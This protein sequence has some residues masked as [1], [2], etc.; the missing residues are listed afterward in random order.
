MSERNHSHSATT[1]RTDDP[2]PNRRILH[3]LAGTAC[4]GLIAIVTFQ[5]LRAESATSQT[6]S[7]TQPTTTGKASAASNEKYLGRVNNQP[8]SYDEV[9]RECV[10][11]YGTDVLEKIINRMIIQQECEKRGI[12][13][14]EAE[15]LQEVQKICKG[16]KLPLDTY[17][18]LLQSEQ[19]IT[20]QQYHRHIIWPKLALQK[21][22]GTEVAVTEDDMRK[23]FERDY[24]PRVEVRIIM[25]DGNIRQANEIWELC[26]ANPQDFDKLAK[27]HSADPNSR[28]LGGVVPPIRKHA[29]MSQIEEE[30]FKLKPGEISSVIQVGT[31]RHVIMKCEGYTKPVVADVKDV[32]AELHEALMEEKTQLAVAEVFETLKE[33][34]EVINYLTKESTVRK[35]PGQRSTGGIQQTSG[36]QTT[37][38]VTPS[39]AR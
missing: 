13:V 8:I 30:A 27:K 33:D 12:V 15:V 19:D 17:Y 38:G 26:N 5:F 2:V 22:A 28:P 35:A 4:V 14:T 23:A 39:V 29:G 16:F 11:R 21:L 37:R 25:V 32:W 1:S 24:G 6:Q 18:Q 7:S 34:A 31:G 10:E 20:P 36:T 9:A 3:L